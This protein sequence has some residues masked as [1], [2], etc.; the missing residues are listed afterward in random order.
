MESACGTCG[1]GF[2]HGQRCPFGCR[3]VAYCSI[4]CQKKDKERHAVSCFSL[5]AD[6]SSLAAL[7]KDH[8]IK[9]GTIAMAHEMFTDRGDSEGMGKGTSVRNMVGMVV[10]RHASVSFQSQASNDVRQAS[11]LYDRQ[12]RLRAVHAKRVEAKE[13]ASLASRV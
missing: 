3:D 4:V 7:R 2:E 1:I 6:A 10:P 12:A 13:A 8:C 9:P 5:A 11:K